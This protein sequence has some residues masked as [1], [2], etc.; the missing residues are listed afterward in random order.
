[1]AGV[2]KRTVVVSAMTMA[3][4]IGCVVVREECLGGGWRQALGP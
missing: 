2:A 3:E 4:E 1:M